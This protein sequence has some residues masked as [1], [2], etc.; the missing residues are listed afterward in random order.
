MFINTSVFK[1]ML[2]KAYKTGGFTVGNDDGEIFIEGRSW[3]LRVDEEYFPNKE[4]AAVVELAGELPAPGEV[5]S[6]KK[7]AVNQYTVPWN[8][9]WDIGKRFDE[10]HTEFFKTDVSIQLFQDKCRVM[11]EKRYGRCIV[12]KEEYFDLIDVD[13]SNNAIETETEGP[14][15]S[16]E[17][18]EILY[19]KNNIMS[20]ALCGV[21][22]EEDTEAGLLLD[23]L[24][25]MKLWKEKDR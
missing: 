8:E 10:I 2:K 17:G 21:K 3:V 13:Q 11:Q 19:W 5:F 14:R 25:K 24:G 15:A 12:L 23:Y 7:D 6:C 18:G 20:L 22:V 4:K 16:D 1:K 9:I